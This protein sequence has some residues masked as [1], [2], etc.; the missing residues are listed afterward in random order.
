V[1]LISWT[2]DPDGNPF[3]AFAPPL[4]VTG[5]TVRVVEEGGGA[6]IEEGAKVTF[7][8]AMFAGDTGEQGFSTYG[9]DL[10]QTI[11]LFPNSMSQTFAEAL[12]GQKVGTKL[13]FGTIDSSGNVEADYLVTQF[14]AVTV[15]DSRPLPLSAE[16][17]DV[18]PVEGLPHVTVDDGGEPSIEI[19]DD[20][21]PTELVAQDLI[22]GAGAKVAE[23][24]TVVLQ[25]TGWVWADGAMFDSTW[26]S[27][28]PQSMDLTV[29]STLPGLVYGLAG[30]RVG[31][32][33]LVVIP[34]SLALGENTTERIPA[35]STLVYVIDILDA[36]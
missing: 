10:P 25:L 26:T 20:S 19:P 1:D 23:G 33:V 22:V 14:M 15:R 4:G 9:T 2:E 3:L 32:R 35:N 7:D 5:P 8:Y 12:I 29:G 11:L 27:G 6:T 21:P 18:P 16:G 28:G 30:K 36:Q 24:Q 34:P 17:E 31:S 13:I